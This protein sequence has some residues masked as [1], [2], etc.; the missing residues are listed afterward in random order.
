MYKDEKDINRAINSL[1]D[2]GIS[3]IRNEFSWNEIEIKKGVFDFKRY[4]YIVKVCRQNN[5]EIL[6]ILGYTAPWTGQAWNDAPQ[7]ET[8]F[9]NYVQI[10]VD[11]YKGSV[12]YWEFWNEPD[13]PIYW[14][15][16]DEMKTYTHLLKKVYAT[17]KKT[18]PSAVVVLGGLVKN[19]YF[20]LKRI[21]SSGG[22]NYFDIFNV[23]PYV[24]PQGSNGLKKITSLLKNIAKEFDKRN[25]NKKIWITEI[26]CPGTNQ[27]NACRWWLGKCQNETEQA[28]FL[29]QIY[30]LLSAHENLEKIFWAMFRDTDH[31]KDGIDSFGLIRWN[32]TPKPAYFRYK[33]IIEDW[34]KNLEE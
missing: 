29:R 12:K 30:S 15:P 16:Q 10:V 8:L 25:L 6:G 24:A 20:S 7:D 11:R 34:Y 17:I 33:Q 23:H 19:P 28:E 9:L 27:I 1:K 13:T 32:Y 18:E 5:I 26:A 31:F 21:L 22:E 3:I 14:N 2:L 4:D